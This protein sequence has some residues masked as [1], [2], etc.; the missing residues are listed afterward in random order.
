M[1]R[2]AHGKNGTNRQRTVPSSWESPKQIP[3]RFTLRSRGCGMSERLDPAGPVSLQGKVTKAGWLPENSRWRDQLLHVDE[4]GCLAG[5]NPMDVPVAVLTASGHPHRTA[6]QVFSVWGGCLV[7]RPARGSKGVREHC[8]VCAETGA[9]VRRCRIYNCPCWP[10]RMG[11]NPHH[12]LRGKTPA[13]G[14]PH[15]AEQTGVG[16][17]PPGQVWSRRGHDDAARAPQST[18]VETGR[19][20]PDADDPGAN[21]Q[22]GQ[23]AMRYH[24]M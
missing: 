22:G 16:G 3:S 4:G 10:Y 13:S 8:L 9:E 5:R 6:Q 2:A 23:G 18:R 7:D 14:P 17:A 19:V 11:R 20:G 12:E 1:V 21:Q 24:Q 15:R